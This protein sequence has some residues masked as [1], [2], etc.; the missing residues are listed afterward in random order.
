MT[1]TT[2]LFCEV[3]RRAEN[4]FRPL[5]RIQF[6]FHFCFQTHH[7]RKERLSFASPRDIQN[8]PIQ[9]NMTS[10]PILFL[11]WW[12]AFVITAAQAV[13]SNNDSSSSGSGSSTT[14]NACA[15]CPTSCWNNTTCAPISCL[16]QA[17]MES[18]GL[19]PSPTP[20]TTWSWQDLL[21]NPGLSEKGIGSFLLQHYLE[22]LQ[23]FQ[24]QVQQCLQQQPVQV[25]QVQTTTTTTSSATAAVVSTS[26]IADQRLRGKRGKDS[27][28][29]DAVAAAPFSSIPTMAIPYFGVFARLGFYVS[30]SVQIVVA[31][32]P[33]DRTFG[34][35][36]MSCKGVGT[37]PDFSVQPV[38]G[39][40][41]AA[42]SLDDMV[43]AWN[44]V[45]SD[46][47][48]EPV[49]MAASISMGMVGNPFLDI[50]F[51]PVLP[52]DF[53]VVGMAVSANTCRRWRI[54]GNN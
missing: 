6:I 43:G 15:D 51:H 12:L 41:L 44:K 34:V 3:A 37:T 21:H 39:V 7:Q 38:T 28:S 26:K 45:E 19:E 40:L 47:L 4:E 24:Q 32:H 36:A 27:S 53:G 23:Q 2:I 25:Q 18:F 13:D 16:Q 17:A 50:S 22:P 29:D 8:K 52:P 1:N 20:L 31:M 46:V 30:R 5:H 10:T 11:I 35:F 42:D 14:Q 9:I 49:E 48:M 33:T 54:F